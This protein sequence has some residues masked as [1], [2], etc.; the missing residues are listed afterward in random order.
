MGQATTTKMELQDDGEF[1]VNVGE[2]EVEETE[3]TKQN[4]DPLQDMKSETKKTRKR[5][6]PVSD[7]A[8]NNSNGVAKAPAKT[9]AKPTQKKKSPQK[10]PPKKKVKAQTADSKKSA[11]P[12][13]TKPKPT[14]DANSE[15]KAKPADTEQHVAPLRDAALK[16]K[17]KKDDILDDLIEQA[18]SFTAE[19][20]PPR[21][22][23]TRYRVVI[24]VPTGKKAGDMIQFTNPHNKPQKIQAK[25]PE[26]MN[27][28]DKFR[29]SVSGPTPEPVESDSTDHNNI[30]RD[31]YGLLDDF[32]R[33][34]DEWCDAEGTYRKAIKDKDFS[35]HLTKRKKFD[36]LIAVFP[37][38]L[39]TPVDKA[40]LQR[41]LRRARQSK[42]KRAQTLARQQNN[43][44]ED[45]KPSGT[46]S[47][48]APA[49]K[50][51]SE[52]EVD[53]RKDDQI[54]DQETKVAAPKK[55]RVRWQSFAPKTTKHF[56][57]VKFEWSAFELNA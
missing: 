9:A 14:E 15:A 30:P 16:L 34:F 13:A 5:K 43:D 19:Q 37:T 55:K 33:S 29:V 48:T 47:D 3:M 41:I 49:P 20:L 54:D 32:A 18:K 10:E 56:K 22:K 12:S 28:G 39:K 51:N 38:G 6:K 2:L 7:S 25:I 57:K 50:T 44:P 42:Q 46:T 27:A 23:P 53:T 36:D 26:G 40:Y 52:T 24:S 21:E 8:T 45:A 17:T 1:F 4:Y 35:A 31:F 11:A